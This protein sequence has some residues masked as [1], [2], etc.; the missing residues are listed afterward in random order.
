MVA[1]ANKARLASAFL[2]SIN[3]GDD[4]AHVTSSSYFAI[5][6]PQRLD[7]CPTFGVQFICGV[8]PVIEPVEP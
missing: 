8:G 6:T 2:K 1:T 3:I 4:E 7:W 5:K